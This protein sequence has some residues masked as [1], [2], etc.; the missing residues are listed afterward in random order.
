MYE[1]L[2]AGATDFLIKPVDHYECKVRCRNLLTMRRQQLIIRNRANSLEKQVKDA[3]GEI[4]TREKDSLHR[5]ALVGENR[6]YPGGKHQ[7]IIGEISAVVA[8]EL[9]MGQDFCNNIEISA[10]LHDIGKSGIPDSILLKQGPLNREESE[11]MKRHTIIGHNLLKESSSPYIR[12]GAVIARSHH[13]KFD[14]NGY[15]DGLSGEQIPIE[16]R[17]VAVADIFEALISDR[18]YRDAIPV[19]EAINMINGYS[20]ETLDPACIKAFLAR[21]DEISAYREKQL[22][23]GRGV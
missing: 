16:A 23:N 9:G 13:E 18:P 19:N 17:I 2:E 1:A 7:Q 6:D 14:G 11:T 10:R 3:I 8:G 12:M 22:I 20:G 5:L 4:Q 21:F 15:P